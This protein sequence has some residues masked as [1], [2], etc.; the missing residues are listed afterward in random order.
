LGFEKFGWISYTSQTRIS[1]FIE[2][3]QEGKIYGTQC[4]ECGCVQFPPRAHCVRCLS[5]SFEW[6]ELTG[7]GALITYTKVDATPSMFKDQSPYFLGLAELSDGP[8]V[9]AW[10]DK[11]IPEDQIGIGM[12]LKLNPTKLTNGNLCYTLAKPNPT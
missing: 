10:I 5:N 3:L 9:F 6:K 11:T 8:K 2:Y 4:K 1:K 12:K 7:D